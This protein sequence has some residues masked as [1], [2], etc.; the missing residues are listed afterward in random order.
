MRKYLLAVVFVFVFATSA[1]ALLDDNSTNQGQAQGQGQGQLQGQAQG[2]GQGQAQGQVGLNLQGQGQVA[3]GTVATSVSGDENKTYAVSYPSLS[4][5]E[6]VS[7]AN[8]YS[9]F[10]GLGL[11][12]TEKYKALITQIQAIEA[13]QAL[14]ADQKKVLVE[15][16]VNKMVES[17]KTK[18]F[19]GLFWETS[20]RD[21]GNLLGLLSFD[22]FWKEG[23]KPFAKQKTA[24]QKEVA[25][26]KALDDASVAGNRGN[27][28]Q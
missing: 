25:V 18:R 23:Q 21:L 2:Q 5:G 8:A 4:G 19:L 16:L 10:G 9:I 28:N 17:N 1:F 26:E 13:M 24:E 14:T 20:G 7:Q 27:V 11:S 3:N 22:S 15:K 12:N 6:G